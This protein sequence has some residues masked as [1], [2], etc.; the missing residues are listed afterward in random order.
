MPNGCSIADMGGES[1]SEEKWNETKKAKDEERNRYVYVYVGIDVRNVLGFLRFFEDGDTR[2]LWYI[3]YIP[4]HI[5]I[6]S[7]GS[8]RFITVHGLY[9]S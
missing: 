5:K 4:R 2:T 1:N 9:L 3:F 7:E 8:I 6:M